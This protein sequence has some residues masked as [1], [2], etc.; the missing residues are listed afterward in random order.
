MHAH[1][2]WRY[3]ILLVAAGPLVYYLL[4]AIAAFRFFSRERTRQI[5]EFTPPVSILKAVRGTDF[6]TFENYASFWPPE[7]S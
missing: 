7:L 2:L 3:A 1:V 4:A 5:P 6:A